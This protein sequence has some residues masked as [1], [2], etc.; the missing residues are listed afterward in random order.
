MTIVGNMDNAMLKIH[1]NYLMYISSE[2]K[3]SKSPVPL[4]YLI[5]TFRCYYSRYLQNP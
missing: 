1:R 4:F 2:A 5:L 3:K